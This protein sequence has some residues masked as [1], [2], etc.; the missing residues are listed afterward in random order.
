MP[1]PHTQVDTDDP[2]DAD[3]DAYDEKVDPVGK[4]Y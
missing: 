3:R 4:H 1:N 2:D